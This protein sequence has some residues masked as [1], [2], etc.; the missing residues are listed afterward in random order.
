MSAAVRFGGWITI[1]VLALGYAFL[2]HYT[3]TTERT[4]TL[5]TVVALAPIVFAVLSLAW[6]SR[7]R[8]ALFMVA[9][10]GCV[11]LAAAWG[12]LEHHFS[13]IYWAEHAGSQFIL[14]LV[15]GR[16][17]NAG[18]EPMCTFFA[19]V[20]H[21]SLTPELERYTRQV[22]VAWVVFFGLMAAVST[23]IFFAA[24]IR[25]WS[26]FA[27]FF[28]GPLIALMF[29]TEY[30]IR[31]WLHPHM[32]HAHILAVVKTIWKKPVR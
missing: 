30:G 19:R 16:T 23:M 12:L 22:T 1:S 25:T 11:A 27:N 18:R 8:T 6:H 24:S 26:L 28:T 2:A 21:G 20:I 10:I 4:E 32:Q 7:S 9:G 15:F 13:W 14:C 29:V 5:G 31:R 17:L 3:N